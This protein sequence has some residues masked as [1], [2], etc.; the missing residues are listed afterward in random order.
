ML[1]F[2]SKDSKLAGSFI[3]VDDEFSFSSF[4]RE[5]SVNIIENH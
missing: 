1:D 5:G 2:E 4:A 3:I